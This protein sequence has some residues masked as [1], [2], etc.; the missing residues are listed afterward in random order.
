MVDAIVIGAGQN[1]L[2]AA[3]LLADAGWSVQVLESS[4]AP[5]GAV[6]SGELTLPGFRHDLFSAFYPLAA[7]SSAMRG[8]Q[9]E[10]HGLRWCHAPLALAHP[11]TDGR[12]AALSNDLDETVANLEALTPG[13]GIA[14]RKMIAEWDELEGPLLNAVLGPFPPLRSTFTLL[15]RLGILETE[16]FARHALLPV[17]RMGEERFAGEAPRLLLAG[18]AL[19]TDLS[20]ESAGSGFYGWLLCC[21]AQRFGFPVPEGGAEAL[22]RALISRLEARGGTVRCDAPVTEIVVRGGR[23]VGVRIGDAEL[24]TARRAVLADV[25]ATTLYRNLLGTEHVPAT[26]LE[27]LDH[28]QWDMGTVK[29]DW[30][31]D[32]PVP[33]TTPEARSAG[34]VHLAD[35]LDDLSE[36]SSEIAR[37]RLP[38]KPFVIFGQQSVADPTRSPLGTETAWAYTH[39]PR[40]VRGGGAASIGIDEAGTDD[41]VDAFVERIEGRVEH[42]APGFRQRVLGRHVFSPAT[43]EAANPS[44]VGGAIGGGTS[45]LHQQL[46]LRPVPG[47]GRPETPVAGLFLASSSAHPGGGVHGAAGAN[48]AAAARAMAPSARA[49]LFGGGGLLRGSDR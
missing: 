44:L 9:L 12:C 17:R 2:V 41:W 37:G 31:L 21:L 15:R 16:R 32:S 18:C 20:P 30:A 4:A 24:L 26:L 33:W 29:V 19:H 34:A 7:A 23:A 38:T 46:W 27:D 13:D 36:F 28:F 43:L 5:G 47:S 48:A 39:V 3:N 1:G 45:Q 8:L 49:W 42:F 11:L 25:P 22:T 10:E 40:S 6:R 35:D 14:W